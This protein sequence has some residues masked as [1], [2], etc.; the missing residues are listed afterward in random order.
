MTGFLDH[1]ADKEQQY[2]NYFSKQIDIININ[3]I[4]AKKG[5][6][7]AEMLLIK[8]LG[9]VVGWATGCSVN[10]TECCSNG[11]SEQIPKISTT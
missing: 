7:N 9:A 4:S 5:S 1:F 6:V 2:N 8:A 10:K 11:P 3:K